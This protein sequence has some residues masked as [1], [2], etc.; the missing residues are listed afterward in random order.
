MKSLPKL[1][2]IG[3]LATGFILTVLLW[4]RQSQPI[5][6]PAAKAE[7]SGAPVARNAVLTSARSF[8][9][10]ALAFTALHSQPPVSAVTMTAIHLNLQNWL[11]AKRRGSEEKYA[12]AIQALKA[13]LTDQ[14]A[15]LVTRSLNVDE[16]QTPFGMEAILDWTKTNPTE[17]SNWMATQPGVTQDE[18]FAVS[19]GW[20]GDSEG[21]QNYVAQLPPSAW[22]QALLQEAGDR[23]A[24]SDPQGAIALAEQMAAG[25]QQTSLLQSVTTNWIATDPNAAVAWING[26]TDP[27]L[28]NQLIAS[29]AQSYALSD[30]AGAAAWLASPAESGGMAKSVALNIA[31]TWVEQDPAAAANWVAQFPPGDTRTAAVNIVSMYW[32]QTDPASAT[33]WVKNLPDSGQ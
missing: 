9:F 20:A 13:I 8:N 22:K 3:I 23:M 28:R 4:Q 1:L 17:A 24:A 19:K 27:A 21:L 31:Q 16:L 12:D 18:V 26:V 2:I 10:R 6:L 29:A 25:D 15:A 7:A 11:D 14:N 5:S 30:P 33:A 32:Q